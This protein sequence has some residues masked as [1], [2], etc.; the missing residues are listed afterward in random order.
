MWT[1][2]REGREKGKTER[3]E[4]RRV[5]RKEGE[6]KGEGEWGRVRGRREGREGGRE[7]E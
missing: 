1:T 7:K 2:E 3:V 6:G 5:R 4:G